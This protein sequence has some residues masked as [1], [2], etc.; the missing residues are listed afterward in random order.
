MG[1]DSTVHSKFATG[2]VFPLSPI[3]L[4]SGNMGGAFHY[5]SPIEIVLGTAVLTR[6]KKQNEWPDSKHDAHCEITQ[7]FDRT[8]HRRRK[9]AMY[10]FKGQ[11]A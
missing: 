6:K 2:R 1:L 3:Q 9:S 4:G 5:N 11:G 8:V 7:R 10:Q